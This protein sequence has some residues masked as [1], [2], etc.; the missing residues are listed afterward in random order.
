MIDLMSYLETAFVQRDTHEPPSLA[1]KEF[2]EF[3]KKKLKE[4]PPT[5]VFMSVGLAFRMAN[6]DEV[7]VVESPPED[8]LPPESIP[9]TSPRSMPGQRGIVPSQSIPVFGG[10]K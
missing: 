8:E 10:G 3:C 4:N 2:V 6:G 5:S 1:V 9:I 7:Q